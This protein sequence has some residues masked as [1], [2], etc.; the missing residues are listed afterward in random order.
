MVEVDH[1]VMTSTMG[2][3]MGSWLRWSRSDPMGS[4][5]TLPNDG[6]SVLTLSKQNSLLVFYERDCIKIIIHKYHF[7]K[8]I[9]IP[10]KKI[11]GKIL[12]FD[13]TSS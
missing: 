10:R 5:S 13:R 2:S 12:K 1:G 6:S 11:G 8:I 3:T 7:I 9:L 4:F